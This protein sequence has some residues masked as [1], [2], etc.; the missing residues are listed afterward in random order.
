MMAQPSRCERILCVALFWLVIVTPTF[1]QNQTPT[2]PVPSTA[3]AAIELIRPSVVR[4]LAQGPEG[5]SAG[6]GFVVS[7]QYIITNCHVVGL[8]RGTRLTNPKV[9]IGCQIPNTPGSHFHFKESFQIMPAEIVDT[10]FDNDLTLLKL[11]GGRPMIGIGGAGPAGM[12]SLPSG[13]A[14]LS[15][16][17]LNDGTDVF[18]S[19]FPFNEP[20]LISQRGMIA[21]ALERRDIPYLN[22]LQ[23]ESDVILL[24]VLINHGN[25]GGPVYLAQTGEVIGV[26]EAFIGTE[27]I[28]A[29]AQSPSA[30]QPPPSTEPPPQ[31][32][33]LPIVIANSGLG[34][35]I[36]AKY[37]IALLAKNHLVA[38]ESTR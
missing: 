34:V 8:C 25:S 17:A 23:N 38:T 16:A 35:A 24:D 29:R 10:D 15:D 20:S 7:Y 22:E 26:A 11:G 31:P 9:M 5:W 1:G 33:P 19:G 28:V 13:V 27:D 6:S 32:A 3:S 37:V 36:P 21:G 4:V 18:L 14:R 12:I 2:K 30:P